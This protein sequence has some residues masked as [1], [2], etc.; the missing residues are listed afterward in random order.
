MK[1]ILFF[2]MIFW[3]QVA[4]AHLNV[5][6]DFIT[7]SVTDEKLVVN[8][9][10]DEFSKDLDRILDTQEESFDSIVQ[11]DPQLK[12]T[13]LLTSFSVSKSGLLGLSAVGVNSATTLFWNRKKSPAKEEV[14]SFLLTD[15]EDEFK[16]QM[17]IDEVSDYLVRQNRVKDKTKLRKN[18]E[19]VMKKAQ[20]ILSSIDSV[21]S[22]NWRVGGY[23]L[24]LEITVSG[25]VLPFTKIGEN[26]RLW[27]EW[28][29]NPSRLKKSETENKTTHFVSAILEDIESATANVNLPQFELQNLYVG[30]GEDAKTGL[31]GIGATNLG[32]VGYVKLVKKPKTSFIETSSGAVDYPIIHGNNFTKLGRVFRKKL[33]EGITRSVKFAEYFARRAEKSKSKNWE[34][35]TIREIATIT[36]SGFLGLSTLK[37]KGVFIFMFNRVKPE[38]EKIRPVLSNIETF[39]DLTLLRLSFVTL[40]GYNIPYVANFEVRPNVEFFWK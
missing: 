7:E 34:L 38:A 15:D 27:I 40:I 20:L 31:F 9:K 39:A 22:P 1:N 2:V 11:S 30:L 4:F 3:V 19:K 10:E 12:L 5:S 17:K 32:F 8:S 35:S 29:R 6:K 24:D 14:K 36:K 18:L 16:L 37:T 23:R 25:A 26:V 21:E 28:T 33:R 13:Q